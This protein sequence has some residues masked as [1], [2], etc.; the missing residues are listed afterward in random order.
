MKTTKNLSQASRSPGRDLKP[1]H[2]GYQVGV[3]TTRLR[4]SVA[5]R[6]KNVGVP[7]RGEAKGTEYNYL[8]P[9]IPS[10]NCMYQMS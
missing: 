7:R 10:G 3:L 1:G 4:R 5:T 2:P 6:R 8:N 9:L